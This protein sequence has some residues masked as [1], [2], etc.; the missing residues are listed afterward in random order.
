MAGGENPACERFSLDK[1][2]G[3]LYV[4]MGEQTQSIGFV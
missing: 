1:T 4:L 2:E 3:I